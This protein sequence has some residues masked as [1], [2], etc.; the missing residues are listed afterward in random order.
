MTKPN[1]SAEEL[2]KAHSLIKRYAIERIVMMLPD[3]NG[4]LRGKWLPAQSINTVYQQG[5][6]LAGSVFALDFWGAEIPKSG[7]VSENGDPDAL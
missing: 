6:R 3:L 2:E 7:M 5:T 1:Y 4:V